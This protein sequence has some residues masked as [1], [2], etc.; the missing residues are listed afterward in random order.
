VGK[1]L[2]SRDEAKAADEQKN[3]SV[4]SSEKGGF[5]VVPLKGRKEK[6]MEQGGR[7]NARKK[8]IRYGKVGE[9]QGLERR[10]RGA[11]RN[12]SGCSWC[13]G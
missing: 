1:D 2:Y 4:L 12:P 5:G 11:R 13:L 10:S 8:K 7:R 3:I 6:F 9:H